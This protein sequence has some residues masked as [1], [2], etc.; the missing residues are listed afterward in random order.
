MA[1][2]ISAASVISTAS[3]ASVASLAPGSYASCIIYRSIYQ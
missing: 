1:S 3:V 2:V